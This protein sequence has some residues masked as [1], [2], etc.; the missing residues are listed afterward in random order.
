MGPA[1]CKSCFAYS[2]PIKSVNETNQTKSIL[3]TMP[4]PS[5]HA[6]KYVISGAVLLI[7]IKVFIFIIFLIPTA[8]DTRRKA[9]EAKK[10][11]KKEEKKKKE[12]EDEF[13]PKK[14]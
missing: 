8:V 3:H 7:G 13:L 12:E 4:T 9:I 5:G 14:L 11:K 1:S 2:V 6:I 10:R